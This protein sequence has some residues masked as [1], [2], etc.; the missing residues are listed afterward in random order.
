MRNVSYY[1]QLSFPGQIRKKK[2]IHHTYVQ[3]F[4]PEKCDLIWLTNPCNAL[5]SCY[6]YFVFRLHKHT[7]MG[8]TKFRIADYIQVNYWSL[9]ML[10]PLIIFL[11]LEDCFLFTIK[12]STSTPK[13]NS[14]KMPFEFYTKYTNIQHRYTPSL[15]FILLVGMFTSLFY[16]LYLF[17]N[18]TS[19]VE[20]TSL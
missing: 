18:L 19:L 14:S 3:C 6:Q 1:I 13:R 20:E 5:Y 4:L 16:F 7:L 2:M 15:F 11:S 10:F 17:F 8:K 9:N 12:V